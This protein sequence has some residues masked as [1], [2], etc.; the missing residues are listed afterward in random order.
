MNWLDVFLI[1]CKLNY[2]CKTINSVLLK[3]ILFT[4]LYNIFSVIYVS[5]TVISPNRYNSLNA[6]VYSIQLL[7]I[8]ILRVSIVIQYAHI[9]N[10]N[11]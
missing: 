7:F 5:N 9:C 6:Y 10:C 8:W 11:E 3:N 4:N 1:L 2:Q